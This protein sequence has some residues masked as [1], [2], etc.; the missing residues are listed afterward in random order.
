MAD[1]VYEHDC[2][3]DVAGNDLVDSARAQSVAAS[4]QFR[5]SALIQSEMYYVQVKRTSE[6]LSSE[7]VYSMLPTL[8]SDEGFI[9][10]HSALSAILSTYRLGRR[11]TRTTD[12]YCE[13]LRPVHCICNT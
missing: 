4:K 12:L 8:P 1:R 5:T 7:I 2:H 13:Q 6:G 3:T 9:L 10:G 11:G